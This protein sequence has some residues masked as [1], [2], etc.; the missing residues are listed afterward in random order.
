MTILPYLMIIGGV[1]VGYNMKRIADS[2]KVESSDDGQDE[3]EDRAT[4]ESAAEEDEDERGFDP[5]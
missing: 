5:E 4:Y 2:S 1:I 3:S